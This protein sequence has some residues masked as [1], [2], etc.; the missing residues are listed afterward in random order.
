M[1][2]IAKARKEDP[3]EFRLKNLKSTNS[4]DIDPMRKIIDE[5]RRTSNYDERLNQVITI[6]CMLLFVLSNIWRIFVSRSK[7]L[8]A[9]IDGILK[10]SLRLIC[11][12]WNL[13]YYCFWNIKRKKR[14]I[15]LLP[16]VYPVDYPPFRYN[17]II[18]LNY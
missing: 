6:V 2:H 18:C 11:C 10:Q 13:T 14:G 12:M 5:L 1:E 9:I 8:T 7:N 16:M 17:V 4:E 3:L 15:N